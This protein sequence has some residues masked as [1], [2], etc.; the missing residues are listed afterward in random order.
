MYKLS[1]SLSMEY[2]LTPSYT[3]VQTSTHTHIHAE[4]MARAHKCSLLSMFSPK[5]TAALS[6]LMQNPLKHN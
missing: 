4:N 2:T 5:A 1:R 3:L 6:P